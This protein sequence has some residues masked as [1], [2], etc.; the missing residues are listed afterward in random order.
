MYL[1][2]DF[3]FVLSGFIMCHV[4]ANRWVYE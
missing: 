4:Y 3:F 2:V 1:M